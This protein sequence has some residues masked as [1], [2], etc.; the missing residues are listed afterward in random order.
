MLSSWGRPLASLLH[1]CATPHIPE[2]RGEPAANA[3]RPCPEPL[4][5]APDSPGHTSTFPLP[6]E[7][8]VHPSAEDAACGK[9]S[10]W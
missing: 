10:L 7:M 8:S 3:P 1:S 9:D 5:G 4:A 2:A 6:P